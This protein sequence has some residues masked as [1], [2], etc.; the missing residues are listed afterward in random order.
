ME[1][2]RIVSYTIISGA[3]STRTLK[4]LS[5]FLESNEIV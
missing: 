3:Y 4:I 2:I 1:L 5:F